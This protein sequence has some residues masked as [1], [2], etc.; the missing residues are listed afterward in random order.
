MIPLSVLTTLPFVQN[1]P[2][3]V[4]PT[5]PFVQDPSPAL[6]CKQKNGRKPIIQPDPFSFM[7]LGMYYYCDNYIVVKRTIFIFPL[8]GLDSKM[9]ASENSGSIKTVE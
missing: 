5:R 2:V 8:I 9:E 7:H 4:L 6:S 1:P 3:S